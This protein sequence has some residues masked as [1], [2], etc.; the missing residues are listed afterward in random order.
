MCVWKV[1]LGARTIERCQK[2]LV[3][4]VD[5]DTLL[6]RVVDVEERVIYQVYQHSHAL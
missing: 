1:F 6:N 5:L 2:S 4:S 3:P